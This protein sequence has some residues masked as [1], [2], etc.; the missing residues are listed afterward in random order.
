[1]AFL[2]EVKF[3]FVSTGLP[4]DTFGVISFRGVEG[5]SRCYEFDISLVATK[6]DIDLA[7]IMEHP[8][9]FT[10]HRP[11]GDVPFHGILAQ[12]E[13]HHAFD[14]Y[15]FYQA[16]LVPKLW[17][18]SLT[19]HNQVF[20]N[21]KVPDIISAVLEDAGLTADDFELRLQKDYP[22]WEYICQ[23][24][25]SHFDFVSRWM[26][27][28]GI[29]YFFE[30]TQTGE[31]IIMTDTSVSHTPMPQGEKASYSQ[32]S[33]LDAA[34]LEEVIT[35]LVC[36]Q[37]MVPQK[38]KLKDYNYQTPSLD[39]TGQAD[40][41][42]EHG[43]GEFYYYGDHFRTPEEGEHL[44]E[45][46]SQNLICRQQRFTGQSSIPFLRPG[47]VFNLEDH[48]RDELNQKYLSIE[49]EHQGNQI[50]Y[51]VSGLR[52]SLS[53]LEEQMHYR[54]N[55][56]A[57]SSKVQF[58]PDVVTLKSRFYGTM[59]AKIDA[60]GS[61]E[62]SEVDDDGRYKVILPFDLSGRANG[63][64]SA[65]VRMMQPYG[66]SN[67]GMHFPLHKGTEVLLTFIDGDPDRPIIAGAVPNPDHPSQVSSGNQ[68]QSLLT[69]SGQNKIHMEDE[70]GNQRILLHSPST[71]AFVRIGSHNDPPGPSKKKESDHDKIE[72]MEKEIKEMKEES[73]AG[74]GGIA[75]ST[76]KEFKI[77]AGYS[78]EWLM[79]NEFKYV[80][81]ASETIVEGFDNK[82]FIG[83]KTDVV[84]GLEVGLKMGGGTEF[85]SLY[86]ELR[87]EKTELHAMETKLSGE[88]TKLAAETTK[89]A[90]Q[91][92]ELAGETN[93][94]AGETTNLAMQTSYLAGNQSMLAAEVSRVSGVVNRVTGSKS[95]VTGNVT[96]MIGTSSDAIGERTTA[97]GGETLAIGEKTQ[98]IGEKT[99]VTGENTI[100]AGLT[101]IV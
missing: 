88:I 69:T 62:Y 52:E 2:S 75:L 39:L 61:G 8:V 51:M 100:L 54:N 92:S 38:V 12:F 18:L 72:E 50:R 19:H 31:K 29:Y 93:K 84:I 24:R 49:L 87:P 41:S 83:G 47:Y 66:G 90:G 78:N 98:T 65:F 7:G 95:T 59:N 67:H 85:D 55:F 71:G 32:P 86:Q 27:R 3:S 81:G 46:R 74:K 79:G 35:S 28:E 97:I 30:Q 82:T 53:E 68:T 21:K 33:G 45:V 17:W 57:I 40:V 11:E 6:S 101:S 99:D 44:A 22:E 63:K 60:E 16:R 10:I 48:F 42:P 43:R 80:E 14:E 23:Y 37:K 76:S 77:E 25:E 13:L 36:R 96:K 89:L 64:A 15:V 5:L 58:R 70:A 73:G 26:E 34:K 94:L 9:T 4:G 91:T 1:M 20:L 56:T